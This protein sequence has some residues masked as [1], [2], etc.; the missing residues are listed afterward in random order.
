MATRLMFLK[1]NILKWNWRYLL[2]S[3]IKRGLLIDIWYSWCKDYVCIGIL[4]FY[5]TVLKQT[6][7]P[8]EVLDKVFI[9]LAYFSLNILP[10][11]T[12]FH[13]IQHLRCILCSAFFST[14]SLSIILVWDH[15]IIFHESTQQFFFLKFKKECYIN[16][17]TIK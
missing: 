5:S 17:D 13:S 9:C 14:S 1:C 3:W 4:S 11:L 6:V 8:M 16:S 10:L 2:P 12:K 7:T 15:W